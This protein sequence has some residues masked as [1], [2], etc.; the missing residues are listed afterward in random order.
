[1]K[2]GEPEN[3]FGLF[4]VAAN[5]GIQCKVEW[6]DKIEKYQEAYL[7]YQSFNDPTYYIPKLK[8][9]SHINDQKFLEELTDDVIKNHHDI[10]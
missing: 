8:C 6:Y 3:A 10:A 4:R 1:M 7:A 2:L 9:L 5:L